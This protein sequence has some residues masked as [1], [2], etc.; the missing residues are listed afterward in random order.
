[1][2]QGLGYFPWLQICKPCSAQRRLEIRR[3]W[4]NQPSTKEEIYLTQR[5]GQFASWSSS[6]SMT[7]GL[8]FS[9]VKPLILLQHHSG[10]R[11][12]KKGINTSVLKGR[13]KLFGN[14]QF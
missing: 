9:L 12:I 11:F 1:M 2:Q 7:I 10:T 13:G 8:F 14:A 6:G 4:V 3:L 5:E